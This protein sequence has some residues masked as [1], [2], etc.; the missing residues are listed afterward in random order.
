MHSFFL[1][2]SH[3]RPLSHS[4]ILVVMQQFY[5]SPVNLEHGLNFSRLAWMFFSWL[6]LS[7]YTEQVF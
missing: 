2:S 1:V 6:F 4:V 5:N 7:V 3:P